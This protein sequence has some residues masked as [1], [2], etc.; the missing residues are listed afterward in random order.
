MAIVLRDASAYDVRSLARIQ[1]LCFHGTPTDHRLLGDVATTVAEVDGVVAGFCI[2]SL[3]LSPSRLIVLSLAVHPEYRRIGV[4]TELLEVVQCAAVLADRRVRIIV[5]ARNYAFGCL[6]H[7]VGFR[8][9]ESQREIRAYEWGG[10]KS[11]SGQA[12]VRRLSTD[13]PGRSLP[14]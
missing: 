2:S 13:R 7:S 9:T 12:L 1:R 8:I 11:G 5:G 4:A 6:L 10:P 14:R 3:R